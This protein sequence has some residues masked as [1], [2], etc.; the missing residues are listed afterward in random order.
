MKRLWIVG[1]MLW[2]V[3]GSIPAQA[4]EPSD[5]IRGIADQ[6]ITI[7]KTTTQDSQERATRLGNVFQA[8]MD[9]PFVGRFVMG[10]N[11]RTLNPADQDAY[12][13][14]FQRFVLTIYAGRLN[15]YSGESVI[16]TDSRAVD[17]QDTIVVSQLLRQN[18]APVTVEWRV[19]QT[20]G[21]SKVIDIAVEGVSMALTQRQ[22]FDS[23]FHREGVAGL[24]KRLRNSGPRDPGPPAPPAAAG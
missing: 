22:E 20:N 2:L 19:R 24:I 1:A 10:R 18:R 11:W 3:M 15:E 23:V 8:A 21:V 4:A 6:T 9:I 12:M 14:A 5:L 16:V 17:G 7:L 13:K